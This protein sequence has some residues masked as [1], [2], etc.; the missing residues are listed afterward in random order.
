MTEE[1]KTEIA[2]R[3]KNIGEILK[4][5]S[6]SVAFLDG[7]LYWDDGN[8]HEWPEDAAIV[9]DDV[10]GRLED[11]DWRDID[12]LCFDIVHNVK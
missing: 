7:M 4:C 8:T 12:N 10:E 6:D 5:M 2:C 1:A 3:L 11:F 9:L